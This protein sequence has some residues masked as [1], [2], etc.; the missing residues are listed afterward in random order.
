MSTGDPDE[1]VR[2]ATAPN[3][4]QAHIWADA[5]KAEGIRCRVVGDY[6][7]A[8]IGDVSGVLPELWV[9]RAD[10][11][12]AE[13][14]LRRQLLGAPEGTDEGDEDEEGDEA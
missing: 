6:L 2:L 3:P 1:V 8:G 4:A 14:I 12:R 10:V 9:K 5:L 7:G 13:E 11:P